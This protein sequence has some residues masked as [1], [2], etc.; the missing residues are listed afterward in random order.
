MLQQS[1]GQIGI[2]VDAMPFDDFA[3][4]LTTG[5]G[6]PENA[7]S[8]GVGLVALGWAPDFNSPLSFWAP[9]VD[10]R[11]IK[12][13]NNQNLPQISDTQINA[14]LDS[15]EFGQTEDFASVNKKIEELV[16]QTVTYIPFS[17]DNVILFRP[18]YLSNVYVQQAL[19]SNYDLV[20]IGVSP[21]PED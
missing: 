2:V 8:N 12:V 19:G 17:S 5:I 21:K 15:I 16:A 3:T 18:S 10:G 14:L 11:K 20:N 1:L 6:S 7:K 9:L 4:Y 13:M